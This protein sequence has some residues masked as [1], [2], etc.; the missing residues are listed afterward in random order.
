MTS[1]LFSKIGEALYGPSWRARLGQELDV[2]ERTIRRWAD[3]TSAIPNGVRGDLAKLC[4]KHSA[5]LAK[6]ADQLER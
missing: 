4:R 1:D 2:A 6:M 3:G 5:A